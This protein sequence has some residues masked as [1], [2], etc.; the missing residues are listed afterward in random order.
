MYD[1]D[2]T[3]SLLIANVD[4]VSPMTEECSSRDDYFKLVGPNLGVQVFNNTSVIQY[5][6]EMWSTPDKEIL[7]KARFLHYL[8]Q[9]QSV[10]ELCKPFLARN[11][12]LDPSESDYYC[13]SAMIELGYA[14]SVKDALRGSRDEGQSLGVRGL[15]AAAR[16]S[17]LDYQAAYTTLGGPQMALA[18]SSASIDVVI[19]ATKIMTELGLYNDASAVLLSAHQQ[20]ADLTE[21]EQCDVLSELSEVMFRV[22]NFELSRRYSLDALRRM[23]KVRGSNHPKTLMTIRRHCASAIFSIRATEVIAHLED[24][25]EIQSVIAPECGD[26]ERFITMAVLAVAWIQSSYPAKALKLFQ[27][28][29][30]ASG[31][32]IPTLDKSVLGTL[33]ADLQSAIANPKRQDACLAADLEV[34]FKKLFRI[35]RHASVPEPPSIERPLP[36]PVQEAIRKLRSSFAHMDIVSIIELFEAQ[37]VELAKLHPEYEYQLREEML[38]EATRM[39]CSMV[40]EHIHDSTRE[41]K[42]I[43]TQIYDDAMVHAAT[44]GFFDVYEKLACYHTERCRVEVHAL[45]AAVGAGQ[46]AGVDMIV[47]QASPALQDNEHAIELA[48]HGA[49]HAGHVSILECLAR[50]MTSWAPETRILGNAL[51]ESVRLQNV[52]ALKTLLETGVYCI[53]SSQLRSAVLLALDMKDSACLAVLLDQDTDEALE[54]FTLAMGDVRYIRDVN[55][56]ELLVKNMNV[57]W[58]YMTTR[59]EM[60]RDALLREGSKAEGW[61]GLLHIVT[62]PEEAVRNVTMGIW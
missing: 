1:F 3:R 55:A 22:E 52:G 41:P 31:L 8:G 53:T 25:M 47:Q 50:R 23:R 10:Y 11:I 60:D 37:I 12:S 59:G 20:R 35:G 26:H 2:E 56:L 5:F 57:D 46:E 34:T 54:A 16:F 6:P 29:D 38:A 17:L 19:T 39:N 9:Y 21:I 45:F 13:L 30:A 7:E 44:N 14:E 51:H 4:A 58:L 48:I 36:D 27:Q 43:L 32:S 15:L 40:V 62:P 24:C 42:K 33:Q 49:I 28:I 18:V 61:Q